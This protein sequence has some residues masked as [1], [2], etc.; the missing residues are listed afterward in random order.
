M[1]NTL[2][3]RIV[4]TKNERELKRIRPI[5]AQ[6]GSFEP[7]LQKL[8]DAELAGMTGVFKQRIADVGSTGHS[9]GPHLH[10]E[11]IRDG[12]RVA[13]GQVLNTVLAR[14]AP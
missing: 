12:K 13:P 10:F 6:V 4:G 8:S 9:T 1:L 11:V 14:N 2:L 7:G 3:T 5:V